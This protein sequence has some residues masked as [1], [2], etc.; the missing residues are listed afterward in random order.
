MKTKAATPLKNQERTAMAARAAAP[1]AEAT[2]PAPA[3]TPAQQYPASARVPEPAQVPAQD[4]APAPTSCEL[5]AVQTRAV[6]RTHRQTMF[7]S[8]WEQNCSVLDVF[9]A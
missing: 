5:I 9:S 8:I 3:P 2:E 1:P 7:V 4:A 6:T